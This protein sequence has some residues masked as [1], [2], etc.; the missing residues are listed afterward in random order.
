VEQERIYKKKDKKGGSTNSMKFKNE[1]ELETYLFNKFRDNGWL[2]LRQTEADETKHWEFP[3]RLDLMVKNPKIFDSTWIGIEL[4]AFTGLCKGGEFWKAIKQ[5]K[6]YSK[7][8]FNGHNIKHW[9]IGIAKEDY[10]W[11]KSM[12]LSN[13]LLERFINAF[14][15]SLGI[16]LFRDLETIKFCT[17]NS[18]GI[19]R[20]KDLYGNNGKVDF[21]FINKITNKLNDFDIPLK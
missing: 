11:N 16:G 17:N 19:I 1:E 12:D 14:L 13:E 6:R 4:K 18:K 2:V 7:L 9:C 8:T 15:N 5:I 21:H 20:I 10:S 3:M